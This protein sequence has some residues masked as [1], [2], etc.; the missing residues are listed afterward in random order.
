M[1]ADLWFNLLVVN[2]IIN[3][4]IIKYYNSDY[5]YIIL[6]VNIAF[7]I[8]KPFLK[9]LQ[10]E[11]TD[12]Y[13]LIIAISMIVENYNIMYSALYCTLLFIAYPFWEQINEDIRININTTIM[14]IYF[15]YTILIYVIITLLRLRA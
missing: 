11:Y 12:M 8:F 1:L 7:A 14:L 10:P 9:L 5:L 2:N 15:R 4:N 6:S 13:S 3:P